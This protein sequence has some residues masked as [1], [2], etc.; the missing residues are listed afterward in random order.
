MLENP[1]YL[2]KFQDFDKLK[3]LQ[4]GEM[5]MKNIDYYIQLEKRERDKFIADSGEDSIVLPSAKIRIRGLE[6]K[7]NIEFDFAK[8]IYSGGHSKN[9]I[10]CM[11]S[12]DHR[13]IEKYK[14]K[15]VMRFTDDQKKEL[16]RF[17]THALLIDD[18]NEFLTRVSSALAAE[19]YKYR[20]G[21]VTYYK[22]NEQIARFAD[23]ANNRKHIAFTKDYEPFFIQQEFRILVENEVEDHYSLSIGDISDI[24]HISPID[25][26]LNSEYEI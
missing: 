15:T 6:D 25:E 10:F 19:Q 17:G 18:A 21:F 23:I 16:R 20:T 12:L 8:A 2:M 9:P 26:V 3:S 5:Y 7:K 13:N 14:N 1:I 4:S 11:F 22:D 24:T